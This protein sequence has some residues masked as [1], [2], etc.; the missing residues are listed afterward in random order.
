MGRTVA[1][2]INGRTLTSVYDASGR[3][4]ERV[5][6]DG[7]TLTEQTATAAELPHP[8]T[9][10]WD[11]AGQRP[12]TQT[13]RLSDATTHEEI[14]SRFFAVVTD[15]VGSPTELVDSRGA[16]AWRARRTAWGATAW[17]KDSAAYTPLRFPGQY[18]DPESGLHYNY[19]RHY[20][21]ETAR[22]A[23]LDPLGL[24][25]A[26]NPYGYV[27]N[28]FRQYDPFGLMSCDEETVV[29]YRG[30]RNWSGNEFSLGRS[31]ELQR[32]YTPEAGVYLTDDFSR[33][34]TQYAGPE[35]VVVRTEVP[36]SFADSVLREHSGPAGRQPE[37]FVDTREG[38]DILNAGNPQVRPQGQAIVEHMMG[39]F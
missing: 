2:R 15:L 22:Y 32:D 4:V 23:S 34:A 24:A 27:T 10:T 14:D 30:S 20:D 7:P 6:W 3:R 25:P 19:H 8:V 12:I 28:P 37:C 33:A 26:P 9:L 11:H 5:T 18:H 13:E 17:P 21:P 39:Q 38:V 1:E 31:N 16:V 35:G 36:R 29:L